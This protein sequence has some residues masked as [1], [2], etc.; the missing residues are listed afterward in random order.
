ML[1]FQL[2]ITFTEQKNK[3]PLSMAVGNGELIHECFPKHSQIG[4]ARMKEDK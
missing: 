3:V 4:T 1:R 2:F